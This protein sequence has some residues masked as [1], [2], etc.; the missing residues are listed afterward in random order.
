MQYWELSLSF[1]Y[2]PS[3]DAFCVH[4]LEDFRKEAQT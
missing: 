4:D 1:Y 2:Q 3:L